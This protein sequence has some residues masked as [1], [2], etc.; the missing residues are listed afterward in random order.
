MLAAMAAWQCSGM[1]EMLND[2]LPGG[3]KV[4]CTLTSF[5]RTRPRGKLDEAKLVACVHVTAVTRQS[6]AR[7]HGGAPAI[8]A[9]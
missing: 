7:R 5:T 4:T 1:A 8:R 2:E 6:R 3:T 9:R